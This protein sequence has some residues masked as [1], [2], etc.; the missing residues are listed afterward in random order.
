MGAAEDDGLAR[1]ELRNGVADLLRVGVREPR[2]LALAGRH[3]RRR[4]V[5]VRSDDGGELGGE[6][7]RDAFHLPR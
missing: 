2:H 3:A 4:D 6:K 1:H 5:T 7:A